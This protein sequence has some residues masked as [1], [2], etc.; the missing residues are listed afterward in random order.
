MPFASSGGKWQISK[1]AGGQPKWRGDGKE[2]FYL[3]GNTV[4]AA[5]VNGEG[6]AF[7][8]GAVR[9][10]FEVP[11]RTAS[12]LGFGTGTVYDVAADGQ[13]FLVNVIAEEQVAL[14]PP[15]TVITNWTATLR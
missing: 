12:H 13:R 10:L 11:R 1:T 6:P 4:M 7:Q 2:L 5:E 8:V 3:A 9:R 15:V 14:P